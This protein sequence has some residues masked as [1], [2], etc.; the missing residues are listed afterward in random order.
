MS[1]LGGLLPLQVVP[2]PP[3]PE[4]NPP[5]EFAL[6]GYYQS[7]FCSGTAPPADR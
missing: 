7:I 3:P 6:V 4:Q 2:P 5:A 1:V